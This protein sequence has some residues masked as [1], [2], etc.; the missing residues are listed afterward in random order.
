MTVRADDDE[1]LDLGGRALNVVARQRNGVMH[2]GEVLPDVAVPLREIETTDS[3]PCPAGSL[4]V[5]PACALGEAPTPLAGIVGDQHPAPFVLL[6]G[7]IFGVRIGFLPLL[8]GHLLEHTVPEQVVLE[9]RLAGWIVPI[10][11]RSEPL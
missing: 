11:E 8:G 6:E 10:D 9:Y 5:K 3:A 1:V 4:L 2:F 7:E